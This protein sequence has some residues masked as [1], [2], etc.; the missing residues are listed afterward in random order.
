MAAEN[1]FPVFIDVMLS[2][3]TESFYRLKGLCS[4]FF[5]TERPQH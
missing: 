4:F 1:R 3:E 2:S 5:K